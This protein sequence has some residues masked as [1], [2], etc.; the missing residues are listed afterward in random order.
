MDKALTKWVYFVQYFQGELL[1][2]SYYYYIVSLG[3]DHAC[4]WANQLKNLFWVLSST[5][6]MVYVWRHWFEI[7]T[8]EASSITLVQHKFWNKGK[9]RYKKK[10]KRQNDN[11]R[12]PEPK[13][14]CI[15]TQIIPKKVENN[16]AAMN[17]SVDWKE[18]LKLTIQIYFHFFFLFQPIKRKRA[19]D[20]RTLS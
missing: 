11:G 12:E 10:G 5:R 2:L 16:R 7:P 6:C 14:R 18:W 9:N 8:T 19:Y 4:G 13:R 17:P 1:K 3:R 20:D 15:G